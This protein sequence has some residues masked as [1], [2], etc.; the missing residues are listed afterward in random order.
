VTGEVWIG[1]KQN[2]IDTAVNECGKHL[3]A[4]VCTIH[5]YFKQFCC[6]QL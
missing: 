6:R 3:H 2:V 4:C 5:P 1:L